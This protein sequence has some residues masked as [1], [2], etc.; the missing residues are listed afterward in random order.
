MG[1]RAGSGGQS[2][3]CSFRALSSVSST[4]VRWLT[5]AIIPVP[6]DLI[7]FLTSTGTCAH[8]HMSSVLLVRDGADGLTGIATWGTDLSSR[9]PLSWFYAREGSRDP[10]L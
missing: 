7:F 6:R 5:A 1:W 10:G 4:Y 3:S 2:G 9:L 8:S